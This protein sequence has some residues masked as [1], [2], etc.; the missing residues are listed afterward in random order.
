MPLSR[1]RMMLVECSGFVQRGLGSAEV[2][3]FV[4]RRCAERRVERAA[5]KRL[6]NLCV[7]DGDGPIHLFLRDVLGS[8]PQ[9]LQNGLPAAQSERRAA[10]ASAPPG[11][12]S[13]ETVK[14]VISGTATNR[15]L[16]TASTS[17][18]I[19]LDKRKVTT[20]MA[21]LIS[22]ALRRCRQQN[23][24]SFSCFVTMPQPGIRPPL[25]DVRT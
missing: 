17:V 23:W 7:R 19:K 1:H 2:I 3:L 12:I 5:V 14:Q 16:G 4:E 15:A 8:E 22:S 6:D 25:S 21:E 9:W 13:T 10:C 20:L 24:T 11:A 18:T